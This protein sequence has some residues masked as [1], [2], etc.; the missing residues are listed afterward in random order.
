MTH[1]RTDHDAPAVARA[2][3]P[4]DRRVSAVP[5][6]A[7]RQNCPPEGV[8]VSVAVKVRAKVTGH[9]RR[10][11]G[12]YEV[13]LALSPGAV[14][15]R[16]L[17]EAAVTAE[18]TAYELRADEA[19]LIRVLT[20]RSLAEDLTRGSVRM[21]DVERPERVDVAAAVATAQLAFDDGI[22]KVFVGDDELDGTTTAHLSDGADVL[23]LRL[24]P[25]AGG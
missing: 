13:E 14:T 24:V 18:V 11:V 12:E 23:F 9:R 2:V 22:F 25:L 15:A 7:N 20:D 8:D 4:F 3:H 10:G 17:I 5:G 1:P 16:D 6:S 21:G 19:S